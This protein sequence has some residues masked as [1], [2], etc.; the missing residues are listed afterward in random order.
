MKVP[1][2]GWMQRKTHSTVTD[3]E[4]FLKVFTAGV[5]KSRI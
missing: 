3:K 1:V 2:E 5:E 4:I